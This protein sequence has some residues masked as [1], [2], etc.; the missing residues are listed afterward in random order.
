MKLTI[1]MTLFA[2]LIKMEKCRLK[3]PIQQELI[4]KHPQI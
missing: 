3:S 2:F 1:Q 4:V